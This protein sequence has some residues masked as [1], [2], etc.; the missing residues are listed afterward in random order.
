MGKGFVVGVALG[1]LT[2]PE[3]NSCFL[4]GIFAVD[5]LIQAWFNPQ[6]DI[7]ANA[8]EIYAAGVQVSK[9]CSF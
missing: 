1:L 2:T 8:S 6:V 5:F 3:Q 4:F 9:L 7:Y